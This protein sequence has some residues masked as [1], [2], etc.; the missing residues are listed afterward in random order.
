[1][2]ILAIS[3]THANKKLIK[4][5]AK[6]AKEEN[7]DLIIHAG[8]ITDFGKKEKGVLNPLPKIQETFLIHGNHDSLKILKK[9]SKAYKNTKIIHKTGIEKNNIGFFGSGTTYW[10]FK[11]EGKKIFDELKK[12]Y[13]KIKHLEKKVMVVHSP[14]ADSMIEMFGFPGSKAIK[15]AIDLFKPNILICGHIHQGG[16]LVEKIGETQVFNVAQTPIIFN[17]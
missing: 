10:G 15:K 7:V 8:D 5:I 16:G 12:G 1:M 4:H 13:E 14:P 17:I 6:I 11:E 2:K 9:I 3:D